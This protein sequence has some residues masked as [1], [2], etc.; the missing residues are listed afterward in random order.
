MSQARSSLDWR[1]GKC[2]LF[3][4]VLPQPPGQQCYVEPFCG[5]AALHFLKSPV[6]VEMINHLNGDVINLCRAI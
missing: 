5:A 3:K 2:R 6:D 4:R 1:G